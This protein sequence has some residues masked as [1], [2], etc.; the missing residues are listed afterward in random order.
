V[1]ALTDFLDSATDVQAQPLVSSPLRPLSAVIPSSIA[2][3][4]CRRQN[5]A[6][7]SSASAFGVQTALSVNRVNRRETQPQLRSSL[8]SDFK[9]HKLKRYEL[10]V[11]HLCFVWPTHINGGPLRIDQDIFGHSV[12]FSVDQHGSRFIQQHF[13]HA[14]PEERQVI[15]EEIVPHH[16]LPL[17]KDVFG[18]YVSRTLFSL[19]CFE[20]SSR[21]FKSCSSMG[22][23]CN[24][25]FFAM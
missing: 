4:Y 3:K 7:P 19:S 21:L 5:A 15:F 18:N 14:N 9:N 12:E 16:A 24:A 20:T 17:M 23:R 10:M 22:A 13:D 6:I 1:T 11:R 8:L 25:S 2:G